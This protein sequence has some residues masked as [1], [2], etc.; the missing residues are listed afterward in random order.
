MLICS[1]LRQNFASSLPATSTCFGEKTASTTKVRTST[2]LYSSSLCTVRSWYS[3]IRSACSFS[4]SFYLASFSTVSLIRRA[5]KTTR[6]WF[7][8]MMMLFLNRIVSRRFR[9]WLNQKVHPLT[10]RE[11]LSALVLN[12]VK[13]R[14]ISTRESMTQ[15]YLYKKSAQSASLISKKHLKSSPPLPLKSTE[16]NLINS[17]TIISNACPGGSPKSKSFDMW[18]LSWIE[19][20]TESSVLRKLQ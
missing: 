1:S 16:K 14:S 6:S 9:L 19:I 13:V 18:A 15:S 11:E 17:D 4:L 7:N 10:S 8:K 5:K 12:L 2:T 20:W 3:Y